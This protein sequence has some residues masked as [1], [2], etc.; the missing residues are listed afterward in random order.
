MSMLLIVLNEDEEELPSMLG[1]GSKI[2]MGELVSTLDVV[3]VMLASP[4]S[5]LCTVTEYAGRGIRSEIMTL[6]IG[7]SI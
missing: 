5:L 3:V 7:T 1:A 4:C 2:T 6:I